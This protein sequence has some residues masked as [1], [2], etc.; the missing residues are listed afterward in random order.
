MHT[1]T[2]TMDQHMAKLQ[3]LMSLQGTWP[4]DERATDDTWERL[5]LD[6]QDALQA[7]QRRDPA[8]VRDYLRAATLELDSLPGQSR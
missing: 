2:A 4:T 7:A 5:L 3:E 1:D 6:L 8:V